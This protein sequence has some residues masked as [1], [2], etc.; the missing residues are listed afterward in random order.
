MNLIPWLV[1]IFP[2][3][4]ALLVIPAAKISDKLR[5]MVAVSFPFLSVL[6]AVLL[7]PNLLSGTSIEEG[8]AWISLP[9]F[10][11]I[12]VGMLVDPL[13]IILANVVA[14]ISFLIMVYSIK[15]MSGD[16]GVARYWFLM[17]VFIGSMLLLV[18]S[19]N[20]LVFYLG[21][22]MVG[23]CSYGLIGYY[24]RD[25]KEHWIGGPPPTSFQKPSD[26]GLKALI[27]TSFGDYALLAGI[28][29]LYIYS[30]SFN[31]M[32][33]LET[34]SVWM[35]EM[36]KT[37][38]IL[39]LTSILILGG[40]IAKSGQFPLHEWLPEAMAG[41]A[42]VSALIHAATMVKA[43]VYLVARLLPIFY[44]GYW[45]ANYAE[46]QAFFLVAAGIGAFT[47]FLA[48]TQGLVSLELKKALAYSTMSQIGY[49]MLGFGVA[50]LSPNALMIG[51]TAGLFHLISHAIFK[52][53]LFL[54][55]GAVIHTA[56]SIYMTKMRISR[57][58]MPRTWLFMWVA[59]LSLSGVPPLSGFWSKDGILL[60]TLEANAYWL[61]A[62]ALITVSITSFYSV[63]LMGLV[64]HRGGDEH[65]AEKE[66]SRHEDHHMG[67][68]SYIMWMP[69]GILAGM[70]IVLGAI[71]P[72][73][74]GF[75]ENVFSSSFENTLHLTADHAASG[76]SPAV[77]YLLPVISVGMLLLGGFPAYQLYIKKKI[78]PVKIISSYG[79][80]RFIHRFLWNRWYMD[81]FYNKVFVDGTLSTRK[82]VVK[83]VERPMD[84]LLNEMV[85]GLFLWLREPVVKY[86]ERPMDRL[87]N[88]MVPGLA[89][90]FSVI[91]RKFDEHVVDGVANGIASAGQVMSRVSRTIQRGVTEEYAFAFA[92]GIILLV[93]LMLYLMMFGA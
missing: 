17:N 76:V 2:F 68:P 38:G 89:V 46:A 75:L 1:W 81:R 36:V 9:N 65:K 4:G 72:W 34:S 40:P 20:L 70:T 52:A 28:I 78:D 35:G 13:S 71:G 15:Y 26:S 23:L 74:S 39:I 42:P 21:W 62:L 51:F 88:E 29:L 18:L 91:G 80:L 47:A 86:V 22:K 63:R 43:G 27:T 54:G 73:F 93:L 12:S 6:M 50:G 61:F 19:D 57:K 41:P 5:D 60:S 82:P 33:I 56:D 16:P 14:I 8:F 11:P 10:E 7:I 87:L 67:E 55:A 44:Y 45:V 64:F 24:Y 83:Y 90:V 77:H 84:R 66:V 49:M 53:A 59:A 30:G 58:L 3:I 79:S 31:Y 69:Y 48:G 37:P 25:K 85:P 92:L 32:T